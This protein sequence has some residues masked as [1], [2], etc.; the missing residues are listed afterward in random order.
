MDGVERF[1]QRCE[2]RERVSQAE[3]ADA[4]RSVGGVGELD[5][6]ALVPQGHPGR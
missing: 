6:G 3:G 5:W 4:L 1:E 2:G